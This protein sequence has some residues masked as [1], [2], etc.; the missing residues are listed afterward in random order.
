MTTFA[1]VKLIPIPP[2]L[3]E[4]KKISNF[5]GSKLNLSIAFYLSLALVD[6]SIFLYLMPLRVKYS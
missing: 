5:S 2:A 4:S 6:P 1:E 3:V